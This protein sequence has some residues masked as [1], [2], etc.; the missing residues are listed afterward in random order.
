MSYKN[1]ERYMVGVI[2][3]ISLYMLIRSFS[4]SSSVSLFPKV[5]ASIVVVSGGLL[6]A[7]NYL[8][9]EIAGSKDQGNM[10]EVIELAPEM[11]DE[12]IVSDQSG[13][14]LKD[15][16]IMIGLVIGYATGGY[17]IGLLWVTPL[18]VLVYTRW[19]NTS[20]LVSIIL[21]VLSTIIPYLIMLYINIDYTSGILGVI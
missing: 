12:K 3:I 10:S 15:E 7:A 9:L 11:P 20:W 4:F 1:V 13:S 16:L 17:L 18:F 8:P 19:R 14:L 6:L 5:T 2:T 21:S